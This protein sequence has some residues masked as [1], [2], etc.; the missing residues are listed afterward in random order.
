MD[1]EVQHRT[2]LLTEAVEYLGCRPGGLYVDCTLGGGG[3]AAAVLAASAPNGRL[4]GLDQDEVALGRAGRRLAAEVAEGRARLVRSNFS[5]LLE[6]LADL[7]LAEVDGVLFDLGVSSFQLDEA[8]RGFSYQADAPLDM[9]M[10]RRV[11]VTAADLVNEASEEELTRIIREYGEER[12]AGRIAAMIAT[13]RREGPLRTTGELVEVIKAAIPA[14][15]RREGPHPAKRTFQALRIAV[16]DELGVLERGL[17][18]GIA[19]LRPGGRLVAISFHSLEDRAVKRAL[20]EAAKG[21]VCP[22]KAPVC[23]CGHTPQVRLLTRHP[24]EPSPAEVTGNPRAR[25]AKLRAA[26]RL[27]QAP[28]E[29]ATRRGNK[30]VSG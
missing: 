8:E 12:W 23:I 25:S 7:G 27:A 11:R 15:A 30:N 22:P 26:E 20:A 14:A 16:N 6:V 21:C 28:V 5:E 13:R 2:V 4:I 18:A 19:A 24:V 1:S 3:H 9:R 10:D 29:S 17:A